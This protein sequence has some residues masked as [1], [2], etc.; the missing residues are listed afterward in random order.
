MSASSSYP[1]VALVT[2]ASR[3][4]GR[5]IAQELARQQWDI[6]ISYV[7]NPELAEE[8]AREIRSLGRRALVVKAD[9]ADQGQVQ[10]M[11]ARIAADLGPIGGLVNNAGIVG[12]PRSILDADAAHLAQ[13][14]ETNVLSAFYC[15]REA[16]RVMSTQRGGRGGVI[17][18]VSSAAARHGGMPNE[19][20]YA[21]SKAAL[22]GFTLALTK[23]L[24]PHGIRV[25]AVRPGLIQ[26]GI[27]EIHGGQALI[28]KV[29]PTIPLA[30]AGEPSEVADVVAF[31]LG[32]KSSYVH[33]ALIDISGGR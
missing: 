14:F 33:G 3:G 10:E 21:S 9:V 29:A 13:V 16:A 19:A 32:A 12:E 8:T 5:A 6:A 30:R 31:L 11:F 28:D 26:T 25:N 7:S 17:V 23:E 2:G 15:T 18:N 1:L 20:H 27:H 24:A 4:L 22:D